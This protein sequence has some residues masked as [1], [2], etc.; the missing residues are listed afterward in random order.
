MRSVPKGIAYSQM[1]CVSK[2]MKS[3]KASFLFERLFFVFPQGSSH[4]YSGRRLCAK[5]PAGRQKNNYMHKL[6]IVRL[7]SIIY[8]EILPPNVHAQLF[9]SSMFLFILLNRFQ[10]IKFSISVCF[11]SRRFS[12]ALC[13]SVFRLKISPLKK[14]ML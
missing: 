10:P 2:C 8:F 14:S 3:K 6:L 11:R 5:I 1:G 12:V 9:F 4:K 7:K 13:S